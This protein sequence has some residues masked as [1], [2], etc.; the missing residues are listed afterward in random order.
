M[1]AQEPVMTDLNEV[2][3]YAEALA[4]RP[5][6]QQLELW[7]GRVGR[8]NGPELLARLREGGLLDTANAV[9]VGMAWSGAEFP[10][11]CLPREEWRALFAISGYT[12]DS[13]STTPTHDVIQLWRGAVPEN[14]DGWS[15]T[16]DPEV[17]AKYAAGEYGR[18][19]G[20]VWTAD[21][22]AASILCRNNDRDEVEYVVDTATIDIR[23]DSG[24]K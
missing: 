17:A 2:L 6:S 10:E 21:F 11:Q 8:D 22:P 24:P 4:L 7:L 15:W 12:E 16:A 13:V 5:D 20:E 3:R 9:V 1:D 19:R 23:R 18:R 14:R